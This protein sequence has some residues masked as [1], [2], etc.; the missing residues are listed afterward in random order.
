MENLMFKLENNEAM[1][2]AIERARALRPRVH[3]VSG[4][5]RTYEVESRN[6][7]AIYEVRFTITPAGRLVSCRDKRTG[8][9]CQGLTDHSF[10]YHVPTAAA[11]NIAVQSMRRHAG[12]PTAPAPARRDRAA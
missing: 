4:D 2:R 12:T 1:K 11:V 5:A 3:V 6:R 7:P 9:P 8:A 10:C